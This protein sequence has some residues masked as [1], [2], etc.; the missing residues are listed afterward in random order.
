MP[1]TR[2]LHIML[3]LL[4]SESFPIFEGR[5][6]SSTSTVPC[7]NF[8]RGNCSY[9]ARCRFSHEAPPASSSPRT[10]QDRPTRNSQARVENS[11]GNFPGLGNDQFSVAGTNATPG[12]THHFLKP[13]VEESFEF[14][15]PDQVYKFVNLLCNASSQNP[16]W[17]RR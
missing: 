4:N 5:G 14:R 16:S 15:I 17:V 8:L 1:F 2:V 11:R 3:L 12:Q 9:G 7:R 10:S 6:G 13:Y